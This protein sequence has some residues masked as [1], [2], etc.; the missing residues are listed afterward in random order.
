MDGRMR[1]E[2]PW[3]EIRPDGPFV[4]EIDREDIEHYKEKKL[5]PD[6]KIDTLL[7]PEPFIGN[8]R[9]AKLVLLN[10]NP[11]LAEGDAKAHAD[12]G[13]KAAMLRNLRHESQEFAF[14]PLNPQ[15]EHTPCANW[16]LKKTRRLVEECGRERVAKGLFV[17]E[18]FPYHSAKSGLPKKFVC[19]SQRYSCELAKEIFEKRKC[20]VLMRSKDH[21]AVC[22]EGLSKL[23]LP[24]SRQ[25][26]AITAANF[27]DDIFKQMCEALKK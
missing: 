1:I 2:N 21:W 13:F 7:I 15:F 22:D 9:S 8:P 5:N 18:W 26:P 12:P 3:I 6:H 10:L 19:E 4:L 16:W 20:M 27:G 25:N 17:I 14:Y 24:N 11:G 23:P